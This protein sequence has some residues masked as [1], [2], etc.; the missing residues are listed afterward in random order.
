MTTRELAV[1]QLRASGALLSTACALRAMTGCDTSTSAKVTN[2]SGGAYYVERCGYE[3]Y[4]LGEGPQPA[5][6][7]FKIVSDANGATTKDGPSEGAS[8]RGDFSGFGERRI[9]DDSAGTS[10]TVDV[11]YHGADYQAILTRIQQLGCFK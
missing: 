1:K 11:V 4:Q 6:G 9:T 10:Y 3:G 7:V 8:L 2:G 5:Y